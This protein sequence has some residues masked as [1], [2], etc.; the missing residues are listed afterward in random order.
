MMRKRRLEAPCQRGSV[1]LVAMVMLLTAAIL[2]AAAFRGSIT[3]SRVI[4]NMQWRNEAIAAANDA[5]DRLLN[6]ADFANNAAVVTTTVNAAPFQVDINGDGIADISTSLPVVT[7]DGVARA[8]PR[9]LRAEAIPPSDLD[10]AK[11]ADL[12]CF[13]TTSSNSSGLGMVT[14]PG[15]V[16]TVA[17]SPSLCS[18]SEWSIT[19]R[20]VDTVTNTSVDVVQGVG[21]RVP[22][23]AVPTCD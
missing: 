8:G 1:L 10:P 13:G 23:T 16:A 20:A 9:C 6:S 17:Q 12:G 21:V 5:I 3:S 7:L 15:G 14:T 2:A 4:G 19:V 22:T 18:N 11:P